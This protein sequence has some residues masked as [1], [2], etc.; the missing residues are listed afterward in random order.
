[1]ADKEKDCQENHVDGNDWEVVSLSASMMASAADQMGFDPSNVS[2][3][4]EFKKSEPESSPLIMSSH[5]VF[6]PMEYETVKLK[7]SN[8]EFGNRVMN[9]DVI[10]GDEKGNTTNKTLEESFKTKLDGSL[11]GIQFSE[12]DKDPSFGGIDIGE[13]KATQEMSLVLEEE[14]LL[15]SHGIND[16][17]AETDSPLSYPNASSQ[18]AEN[19]NDRFSLPCGAWWK[20]HAITLYNHAKEAN[21]MWSVIVVAALM[22]LAILGQRKQQEK[23]QLQQ[24]QLR[25]STNGQCINLML[26]PMNKLESILA[27]DHQH[28][29]ALGSAAR[30]VDGNR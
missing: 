10:P 5:F 16:D 30:N 8:C 3:D 26:G 11:H 21:T 22:G 7:D 1:M 18:I 4:K 13:G 24:L 9:E 17:H 27:T 12:K 14:M 29:S 19:K 28:G 25:L 6:P 20:R 23:P 2:K 15:N